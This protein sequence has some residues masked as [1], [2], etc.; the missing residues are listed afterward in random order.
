MRRHLCL[1]LLCTI[2][3]GCADPAA[4]PVTTPQAGRIPEPG[5]SARVEVVEV[6]DGDT[7][8]IE[9]YG[10]RK[11]VRLLGVDTPELEPGGKDRQHYSQKALENDAYGRARDFLKQ[12]VAGKEVELR[13]SVSGDQ[14]DN[15][16]SKRLL[17]Y[18]HV[19]DADVNAEICKQGYSYFYSRYPHDRRDEFGGYVAEAQAAKRGLWE[20]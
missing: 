11:R 9:W 8:W 6:V 7:F 15:T 12:L 4:P 2:W 1:F 14:I 20:D 16:S 18:V 19:G 3:S 5:A 10:E 13:F 17:A